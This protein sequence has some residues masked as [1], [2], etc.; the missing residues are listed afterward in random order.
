M[1]YQANTPDDYEAALPAERREVIKK[2]R[3]LAAEH[4]PEGFEETMSYGMIGYV[5]PHE[6]YPAGYHCDPSLPLPFLNIASQKNYVAMY[7]SGLYADADLHDWFVKAYPDHARY[8]LDMGKSCVRFKRMDDIPYE[9]LGELF[10][11][12]TLDSWIALYEKNVKR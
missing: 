5:V 12:I 11:K 4:L 1:E 2:L 10:K 3:R 9:L 7:H 6:R 8:K